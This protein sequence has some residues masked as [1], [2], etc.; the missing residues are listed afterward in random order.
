M[1]F[2]A[3]VF[4]LHIRTGHLSSTHTCSRTGSPSLSTTNRDLYPLH[5]CDTIDSIQTLDHHGRNY[6]PCDAFHFAC[7]H[8]CVAMR[9]FT[10]LPPVPRK[11]AYD[12]R[13]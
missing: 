6:S 4:V 11:L 7:M 8:A 13:L 9:K 2:L 12:A 1:A 10:F 3:H 5:G